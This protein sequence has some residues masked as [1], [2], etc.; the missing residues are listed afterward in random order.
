MQESGNFHERMGRLLLFAPLYQLRKKEYTLAPGKVIT[1]ME[2]GLMTLLFFFEKMLDGKRNAGIREL[3]ENLAVETGGRLGD[4]ADYEKI[5]RE[6]VAVFRPASGRRRQE[7]FFDYEKDAKGSLNFTYL[8][9]DKAS[10]GMGEQYYVLDEQGLELLFATKEYFSEFQLSLNQ[11]ILRKQLE[12]GQFKLALRQIEEMRID[13]DTIRN[14][15]SRVRQE[16][17]RS[18]MSEKTLEHY[19]KLV[20]DI[21][22]RLESEEKTFIELREFVETTRKNANSAASDTTSLE[23]YANILE[24]E[25]NL[26]R[27][28]GQHRKLLE[29]GID[30]EIHALRAVEEALYTAGLDS[31]NFSQEI[32]GRLFDVPLPLSSA[33]TLTKPF[34]PPNY[35]RSW[36]FFRIFHPQR[37]I[38]LEEAKTEQAFPEVVAEEREKTELNNIRQHYHGIMKALLDFLQERTSCSLLDFCAYLKKQNS[39]LLESRQFYIFW[40]LLHRR[41][42]VDFTAEFPSS[43]AFALMP[44]NVPEL[45]KIF[46]YDAGDGRIIDH[47]KW[48]ISNMFIEVER[49]TENAV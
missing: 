14:R 36:S 7:I 15:I 33:R 4:G 38:R 12:R 24:V 18:I 48:S 2:L 46:V 35:K 32:T 49:G 42:E 45:K 16:I 37:L 27:V 44:S 30:M 3:A 47:E 43:S 40:M 39:P 11:I 1:G 8:K 41:R 17:H 25:K 21:R 20:R 28:H 34:M 9:A 23:Y 31:F 5:A 6:I 10:I 26:E 29:M 13:V 19:R 22:E